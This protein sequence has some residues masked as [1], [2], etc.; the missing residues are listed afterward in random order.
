MAFSFSA[1]PIAATP[2]AWI[3]VEKSWMA[4]F[5]PSSKDGRTRVHLDQSSWAA[6]SLELGAPQCLRTWSPSSIA[7]STS[8]YHP[9]WKSELA[10]LNARLPNEAWVKQV[11]IFTLLLF[12][13]H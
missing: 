2:Y 3:S 10:V 9:P 11:G 5:C 1:F 13:R 7:S 6:M 12:Q 8:G 4:P